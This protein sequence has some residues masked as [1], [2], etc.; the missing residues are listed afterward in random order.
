MLIFINAIALIQLIMKVVVISFADK[1]CNLADTQMAAFPGLHVDKVAELERY[2]V[3]AEKIKP[4]VIESVSYLNKKLRSKASRSNV[5][6]QKNF[7]IMDPS[8]Q[9]KSHS[10]HVKVQMNM[11]FFSKHFYF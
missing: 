11:I 1:F 2:K 9:N 10:F 7:K 6:T 4:L 8:R 3:F 5:G